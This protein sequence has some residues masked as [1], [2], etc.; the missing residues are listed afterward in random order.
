MQKKLRPGDEIVSL[1]GY[2]LH[3]DDLWQ[4]EYYLDSGK[5]DRKA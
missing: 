3:R 5:S 4:L 2:G 1:D